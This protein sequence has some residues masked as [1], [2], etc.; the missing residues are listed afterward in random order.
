MDEQTEPDKCAQIM[1]V[2]IIANFGMTHKEPLM[3]IIPESVLVFYAVIMLGNNDKGNIDQTEY[4]GTGIANW[5][6]AA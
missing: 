6:C 3:Q 4:G 1:M 5:F 2:M